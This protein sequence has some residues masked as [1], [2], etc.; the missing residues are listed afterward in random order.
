MNRPD[1]SNYVAHFTSNRRP[2]AKGRANP[3][4]EKIMN[5]DGHKYMLAKN[6]LINI[7]AER[8]ITA[9]TIVRLKVSAVCFTECPWTSLVDHTN[10][11]S[12]YGIGF[13]KKFLFAAGGSPA[14]YVRPDYFKTVK[15]WGANQFL[16]TP[17]WPSYTTE[18][19]KEESKYQLCDYSQEREWRVPGDLS[20][21]YKDIAF[22]VIKDYADIADFPK[23]Y[24]NAIGHDKFIIMNNYRKIEDL[25][26][27]HKY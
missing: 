17:F 11:Y 24:V 15:D 12:P 10:R 4:L 7:L 27:V 26:P 3:I 18:K 25:W 2:T 23:E 19:Q 13:N 20:F 22:I 9:S 16:V 1:F 8:K 6:R 14:L 5:K 21:S